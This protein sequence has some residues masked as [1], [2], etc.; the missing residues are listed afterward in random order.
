MNFDG[1]MICWGTFDISK[2]KQRVLEITDDTWLEISGRQE[3]FAVHKKTQTIP[4]VLK[5]YGFLVNSLL[6]RLLPKSEIPR[7]MDNALSLH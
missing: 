2:L 7:H 4:L 6:V 5:E 1:D 3:K